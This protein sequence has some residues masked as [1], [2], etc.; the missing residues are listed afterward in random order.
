VT[1]VD[2]LIEPAGGAFGRGQLR[3]VGEQLRRGL[4]VRRALGCVGGDRGGRQG[5][6]GLGVGQDSREQRDPVAVLRV[7][8]VAA[9]RGTPPVR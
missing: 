2:E 1:G 8:G 6:G 5:G 4:N 7:L 3:G 9:A